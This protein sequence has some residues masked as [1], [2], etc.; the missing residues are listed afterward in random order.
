MKPNHKC[1]QIAAESLMQAIA[2]SVDG[3]IMTFL[4]ERI[5]RASVYM[6]VMLLL[7]SKQRKLKQIYRHKGKSQNGSGETED[8]RYLMDQEP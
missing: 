2:K 1:T 8:E 5:A 3:A 6:C 7:L 4:R